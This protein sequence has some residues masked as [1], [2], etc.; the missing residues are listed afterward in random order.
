MRI[1]LFKCKDDNAVVNKNLESVHH[2][3]SSQLKDT[4]NVLGGTIILPVEYC[5]YNYAYIPAFDRYYFMKPTIL[6]GNRMECELT[7]DVLM[8]YKDDIKNLEC[9]IGRNSNNYN[10]YFHDDNL[11][12]FSYKAVQ[13]KLFSN[14][15]AFNH[16]NYVLITV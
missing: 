1:D 7:I 16:N 3:H 10:S 2:F 13:T 8:T 5:D 14:S 12:Q 15:D 6:D 11:T 9:V 4:F